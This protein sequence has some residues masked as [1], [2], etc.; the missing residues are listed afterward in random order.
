MVNDTLCKY[1]LKTVCMLCATERSSRQALSTSGVC[2]FTFIKLPVT[3]SHLGSPHAFVSLSISIFPYQHI[4]FLALG[5]F[6]RHGFW[7]P[8]C[9][10]LC[11]CVHICKSCFCKH[12]VGG[13]RLSLC[14][15]QDETYD[16]DIGLDAFLFKRVHLHGYV[17]STTNNFF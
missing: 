3:V 17:V 8:M 6:E 11:A 14:D 7:E 15:S 4:A 2:H 9:N 13:E 10:C 16:G 5:A 1:V 12:T